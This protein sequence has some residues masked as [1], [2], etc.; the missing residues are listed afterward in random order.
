MVQGTDG[1][2]LNQKLFSSSKVL[3]WLPSVEDHPSGWMVTK[4]LKVVPVKGTIADLI[5]AYRCALAQGS[6]AR[7]FQFLRGLKVQHECE[8]TSGIQ[9]VFRGHHFCGVCSLISF[10]GDCFSPEHSL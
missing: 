4:V 2:S 8:P 3:I 10:H 9:E 1:D 6:V 5:S 7:L